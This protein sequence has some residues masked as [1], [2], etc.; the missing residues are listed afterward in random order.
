MMMQTEFLL[1]DLQEDDPQV[2]NSLYQTLVPVES[3][4]GQSCLDDSGDIDVGPEI[5]DT[6]EPCEAHAD[7]SPNADHQINQ[8]LK[9]D[10]MTKE[11]MTSS[12][13]PVIATI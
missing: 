7:H 10:K 9:P 4:T 1:S 13:S 3:L 11:D 5:D 2:E 6:F 8:F 12:D